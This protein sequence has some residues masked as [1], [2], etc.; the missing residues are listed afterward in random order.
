MGD[1]RLPLPGAI[2]PARADDLHRPINLTPDRLKEIL[3]KREQRY[4]GEQLTF[5]FERKRIMLDETEVARGLV[6]GYVETYSYADG[7]LDVRWKGHS[8]SYRVF[9]KDQRVTQ[10]AI[11]ENKRLG[12]VLAYIKERQDQLPVPQVKTNSEKGGYKP[13]GRKPGRRTDFI[14]DPAVSAKR[15]AAFSRRD[16]AE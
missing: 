4:V 3:C 12:E 7:R 16:A 5:S 9:D 13:T 1:L 6:G 14:S 10:A 15:Q 8:L 2:A 11:V